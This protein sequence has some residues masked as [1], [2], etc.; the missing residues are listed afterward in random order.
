MLIKLEQVIRWLRSVQ[1]ELRSGSIERK[2]MQM[3]A[4]ALDNIAETLVEVDHR[5]SRLELYLDGKSG[6][7]SQRRSDPK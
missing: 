1:V 3:T 5:L 2:Q 4:E 6:R 7:R